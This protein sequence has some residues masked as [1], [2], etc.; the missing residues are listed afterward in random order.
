MKLTKK[1]LKSLN[2]LESRLKL[3]MAFK[4]TERQV[5]RLIKDNKEDGKLTNATSLRLIREITGLID[6]QILEETENVRA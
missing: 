2:N 5:S 4:V 1:A 6:S 3:A